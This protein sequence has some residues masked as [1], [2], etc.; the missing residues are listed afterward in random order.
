[1]FNGLGTLIIANGEKFNG[2][3]NNGIIDGDG[4][5]YLSNNDVMLIGT[6]KNN[7]LIDVLWNFHKIICLYDLLIYFLFTNNII[8]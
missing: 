3:F 1:M 5:Y 2:K 6:W 4:T 8:M 7:K